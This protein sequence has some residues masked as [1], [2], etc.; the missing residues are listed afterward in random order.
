MTGQFGQ[1]DRG[2]RTLKIPI[3]PLIREA[4]AAVQSGEDFDEALLRTLKARHSEDAA[5][6]LSAISHLVEAEGR[7]RGEDKEQ[8]LRRLAEAA[9]GPEITLNFGG[10]GNLAKILAESKT[11]RINNRE[12][13]SLEEMPPELRRMV[14]GE[15]GSSREVP[16]GRKTARFGC[17]FSLLAGLIVGL[18]RLVGK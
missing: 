16:R 6:L 15:L 7:Q 8:T 1:N 11:Y 12:Y 14:E 13:H 10:E 17:T 4:L 9:P 2:E 5:T 18:A 3:S